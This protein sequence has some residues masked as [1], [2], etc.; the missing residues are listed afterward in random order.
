MVQDAA[1]DLV[2]REI[3]AMIGNIARSNA[4]AVN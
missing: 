2:A 4:A 3:D 1:P